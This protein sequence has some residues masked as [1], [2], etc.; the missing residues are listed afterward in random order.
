MIPAVLA[1]VFH[2]N[3][4]PPEAV[5]VVL[6]PA[7]TVVLP[8]AVAVIPLVMVTVTGIRGLLQPVVGS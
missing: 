5:S 4:L 2:L 1:P 3:V 6:C 7:H 8:M